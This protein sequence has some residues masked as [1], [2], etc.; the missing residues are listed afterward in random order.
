MLIIVLIKH[1][2][3]WESYHYIYKSNCNIEDSVYTYYR[4]S[5]IEKFYERYVLIKSNEI[6]KM[7][8]QINHYYWQGY[9]FDSIHKMNI[10]KRNV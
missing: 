1:I 2:L 5:K 8:H 6:L 7:I 10:K 4:Y 3:N 9:T